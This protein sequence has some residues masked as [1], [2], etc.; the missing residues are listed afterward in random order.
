MNGKIVRLVIGI[1]AATLGI[2]SDARA[3]PEERFGPWLYY[4]PY[5]FPRHGVCK[6]F[7]VGPESFGPRYEDPNPLSPG[8]PLSPPDSATGAGRGAVKSASGD[9]G[10]FG[11]ARSSG[12]SSKGSRE[13]LDPR[14][15]MSPS[16][17]PQTRPPLPPAHRIR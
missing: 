14:P 10:R 4:A 15:R 12:S 2:C 8:P 16:I 9:T 3:V 13:S 6:G 7:C 1:F 11:G 17:T 5:Y